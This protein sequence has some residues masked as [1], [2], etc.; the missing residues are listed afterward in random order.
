MSNWRR[1][2][3]RSG[4]DLEGPVLTKHNLEQLTYRRRFSLGASMSNWKYYGLP[5]PFGA[6]LAASLPDP[7]ALE[8]P[9]PKPKRR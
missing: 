8:S 9:T 4:V 7:S 1:K 5:Q 2:L 6:S 3:K